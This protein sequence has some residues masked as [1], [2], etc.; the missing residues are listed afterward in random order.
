MISDLEITLNASADRI[1]NAIQL[2]S[3]ITKNTGV[4]AINA[5][6]EASRAG[7]AGL[8]FATVAHEVELTSHKVNQVMGDINRVF[9]EFKTETHEVLRQVAERRAA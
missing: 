2:I 8:G 5:K 9:A 7:E 1:S 4:L 6:I 3:K